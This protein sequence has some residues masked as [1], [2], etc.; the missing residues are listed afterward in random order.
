[1][2]NDTKAEFGKLRGFLWPVYTFELKKF[3]PM[4]V[5]IFCILFNYTILRDTKDTIVVVGAGAEAIP[6]L[7]L[8]GVLPGAII[9]MLIYAK[10]SNVLS[11]EKLFYAAIVPFIAF[12]ALY[13]TFFYPNSEMLHLTTLGAFLRENL[14]EGFSAAIA[15]IEGWPS[16]LFYVMSELWGSAAVSLL[17]WGFANEITKNNESKRF[18]TLFLLGGNV[19]LFFSGGFIKWASELRAS[20]TDGQDPWQV[21]LNYMMSAVVV[22]ALIVMASYYWMNRNVLT[23]KRFYDPEGP[24]KAKKSKPKMTMKESFSF[25]A[26]SKYLAC[27][28]I[29]VIAYG[30]CIN[31][32]EVTWKGQLKLQYTT[33]NEYSAFMGGFSQMV[34]LATILITM[35]AGG[36]IRKFGW[37][38]SALAT[39]LMLGA[40]ALGFFAFILFKDSLG[41]VAAL[42][43]ST[44]LMLAVMLG[45]GQNI[46]SKSTKYSLFDTTKEMAYIPLDQESKV[47]GKAAIDVVGARLGKSGGAL[48]N[49]G[50]IVLF[51]SLDAIT[52]HLA[53][54]LTAVIVAW[55]IATKTLGK[56]YNERI[57]EVEK[58]AAAEENK[59]AS[60]ATSAEGAVKTEE[61]AK[62][63]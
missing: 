20:I 16:S 25:L 47:K 60:V 35:F 32:V 49:M 41:G 53:L 51:G 13:P 62:A 6:F 23:D 43:G 21:S 59:Q 56:L 22:M 18:Y 4:L 3:L 11:R 27:L 38:F 33:S 48:I 63:S 55:L 26:S 19:A 58:E 12:F 37:S 52:P 40:T 30:I 15:S 39:P 34:G 8:F 44:P 42:V 54:L 7:K 61:T 9:F 2:S 17:F 1:M 28:A 50:L 36:I 31:L 57:A 29:L 46:L 5:M 10:L 14:P 24:K 45:A